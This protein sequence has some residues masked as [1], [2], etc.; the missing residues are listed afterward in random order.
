[1]LPLQRG[2][3]RIDVRRVQ[4]HRD[5]DAHRVLGPGLDEGDP[6]RRALW[7]HL[8]PA[9]APTEWNVGALLEAEVVAVE[10]DRLVLVGDG[11]H[12]DADLGDVCRALRV[13]HFGPPV[14]GY[15]N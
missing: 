12:D 15:G 2:V 7:R 9:I 4:A 5:L 6:G 3:V 14:R 1:A 13:C 11:D 8:D 10:L